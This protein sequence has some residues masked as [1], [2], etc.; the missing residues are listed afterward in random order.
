MKGHQFLRSKHSCAC[1]IKISTHAM[2]RLS[3]AIGPTTI[4][5]A[6]VLLSDSELLN[7]DQVHRLGYRP[8]A[9]T[10]LNEGETSYYLHIRDVKKEALAVL[11]DDRSGNRLAWVTSYGLDTVTEIRRTIRQFRMG[12]TARQKFVQRKRGV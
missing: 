5:R 6:R 8:K 4:S 10:R 2:D 7:L 1:N 12:R 3:E 9:V 11:T